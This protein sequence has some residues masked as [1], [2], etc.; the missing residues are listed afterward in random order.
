[1]A[2]PIY[3]KYFTRDVVKE[4]KW[5]GE[6]IGLAAVPPDIIPP[7]AKMNLGISVIRKPYMFHEPTHK[8]MFSE[9]FFF[10][11]SNPYDMHEFD[12]E[13]EFSFGAEHEK[14]VISE[15]TIVVA[16]PG[17]Y[18][19][20]LNYAK[21]GKPFYC[22]EAFLT[23]KYSGVDLGEDLSEIRIDE[24]DYNRFFT[25]GAVKV[26]KWGGEGMGLSMVPEFLVP[27]A[28]RMTL[29][30]TAIKKPYMF[31][32]PTHKHAFTEFF[33][34]FG[35][36][37]LDMKEFDADIEFTFGPEREKHVISSPTIVTIPPG[38]YHCPLN[39]ARV[40]KPFYCIEA[41]MTSK[42]SGTNLPEQTA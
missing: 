21:V 9:F 10:F 33:I 29:A 34:F 6:A 15:P 37:P 24:P 25:K 42:Y 7:V 28:S 12:G 36:N 26:N 16:P 18:H 30:L 20:P 2:E 40:G 27:A 31:H 14:H 8:H 1:M 13:A 4:N 39:Y 11:G 23:S 19:C 3:E 41:F 32:E 35:S 5:G 17:V 38:V 22:I